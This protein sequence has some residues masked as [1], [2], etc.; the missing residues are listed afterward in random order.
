MFQT[1]AIAALLVTFLGITVHWGLYPLSTPRQLGGGHLVRGVVHVLSLLLIEQ[2]ASF[3]GAVKKVVFLVTALCFVILALTGFWPVLVKGQ[4]ISGYLMMI[5]A[6]FAP[7]FALCL[8]ILALTWAGAHRFA[9][10]DCAWVPRLLRRATRLSV[11]AEERPWCCS[12]LV[13]K[14]TF[15]LIL[16]LALPLILSIVVSMFHIL[17]TGWQ[18]ITLAI[19]RWTGLVF[20]ITGLVFAYSAVRIRMAHEGRYAAELYLGGPGRVLSR[21]VQ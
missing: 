4:H 14:A 3:L 10:T 7:V 8:A 13:N 18:Y 21:P 2:R 15:W 16:F 12:L 11:P 9:A 1:T 6:T 20:V 19:H 5:H 17:G